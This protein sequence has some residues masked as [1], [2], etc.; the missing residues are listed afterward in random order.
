MSCNI[1]YNSN[2]SINHVKDSMGNESTLFNEIANLP[3]VKTKQEALDIIKQT[4]TSD[5]SLRGGKK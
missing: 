1:K 2:G 3:F 5:F 4:L